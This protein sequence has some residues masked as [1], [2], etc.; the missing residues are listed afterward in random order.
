LL[1]IKCNYHFHISDS[2]DLPCKPR[3]RLDVLRESG[4]TSEEHVTSSI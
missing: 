1:I 2:R 3:H 4:C